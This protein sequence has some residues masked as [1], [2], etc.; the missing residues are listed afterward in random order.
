MFSIDITDDVRAAAQTAP[1]GSVLV[2]VKNDSGVMYDWQSSRPDVTGAL[3]TKTNRGFEWINERG[4]SYGSVN[5]GLTIGCRGCSF[6]VF[7]EAHIPASCVTGAFGFIP[8]EDE[9][10]ARWIVEVPKPTY[11]ISVDKNQISEGDT[12]QFILETTNIPP[13]TV[14]PLAINFP[15]VP[16]ISRADVLVD[17]TGKGYFSLN[18]PANSITRDQTITATIINAPDQVASV[19]VVDV[20]VV[21]PVEPTYKL[22]ANPNPVREGDTVVFKFETTGVPAGTVFDASFYDSPNGDPTQITLTVDATGVV[23]YPYL[24]P[25]DDLDIN[26]RYI[27][28]MILNLPEEWDVA[29]GVPVIDTTFEG[30]DLNQTYALTADVSPVREGDTITYTLHT[31]NVSEGNTI[32]FSISDTGHGMT[33]TMF[34]VGPD[35]SATYSYVVPDDGVN[36]TNRELVG[37]LVHDDAIKV[38]TPV[39]DTTPVGT[40]TPTYNLTASPNPVNEGSPVV[41]TLA[42]TNVAAGTMFEAQL[43]DDGFGDPLPVTF[44]VDATGRATHT[45]TVPDNGTPDTAGRVVSLTM[46]SPQ[47]NGLNA[48]VSVI[49]TTPSGGGEPPMF[50]PNDY[51]LDV[52]ISDNSGNDGGQ[53]TSTLS[54]KTADPVRSPLTTP[55][56]TDITYSVTYAGDSYTGY[57]QGVQSWTN[58]EP[59][60]P[61]FYY[62]EKLYKALVTFT[63]GTQREYTQVVAAVPAEPVELVFELNNRNEPNGYVTYYLTQPPSTTVDA[64][65]IISVTYKIRAL[66]NNNTSTWS[67]TTYNGYRDSPRVYAKDYDSYCLATV[68]L[69]DG[70]TRQY[71]TVSS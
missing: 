39:I 25:K 43:Y 41:F 15:E 7:N 2:A 49:N 16:Q 3:L 11:K 62:N 5:L 29:V 50:D 71:E 47:T 34:I 56:I 37:W 33:E 52:V 63:D 68:K 65:Q 30:P 53:L 31:T 26:S 13:N 9:D 58:N 12:V 18:V 21:V 4:E 38:V 60:V 59:S 70:T 55:P 36:A 57:V 10:K 1:I 17:A 24:V 51:F 42:T 61:V 22:T 23:T 6:T 69:V 27:Y 32:Y 46:L 28:L 54:L 48:E 40:P 64:S 66:Q 45:Y 67:E 14:V 8:P 35:G 19:V 44:T 20:P